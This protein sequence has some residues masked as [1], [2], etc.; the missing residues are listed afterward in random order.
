ML[1][2]HPARLAAVWCLLYC[3]CGAGDGD[4]GPQSGDTGTP[5]GALPDAPSGLR[6]FRGAIPPDYELVW[7]QPFGGDT[8]ETYVV[9]SSDA[10]FTDADPTLQL[11]EGLAEDRSAMI[12]LFTNSGEHHLRVAARDPQGNEGPLSEP[13]VVDTTLRLTFVANSNRDDTEELFVNIPGGDTPTV[14]SGA[15]VPFSIAGAAEWSPDGRRVAYVSD[16]EH[17]GTTELFLAAADG[18][19]EPERISG[20]TGVLASRVL[21]PEW[22]PTTADLIYASDR[23]VLGRFRTYLAPMNADDE[24]AQVGDT[25]AEEDQHVLALP[26]AWLRDGTRVVVSVFDSGLTAQLS[27][28]IVPID[29]GAAVE[30]ARR[31]SKGESFAFIPG[32]SPDERWVAFQSDRR[33]AG[34]AELFVAPADGSAAP[35]VISGAIPDGGNAEFGV[36]SPDSTLI[37]L[38][39]TNDEDESGE[40]YVVPPDGSGPRRLMSGTPPGR[41]GASNVQWSPDSRQIAFLSDKVVSTHRQAYVATVAVGGEPAKVG[42]D[43][44]SRGHRLL[45]WSPLGTQVAFLNEIDSMNIYPLHVAAPTDGSFSRAVSGDPETDGVDLGPIAW[46][47]SPDGAFLSFSGNA[48]AGPREQWIAL[49]NGSSPPARMSGVVPADR[50]VVAQSDRWSSL[51]GGR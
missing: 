47:W 31:E 24:P 34:K 7:D 8:P 1:V 18:V 5:R 15:I 4:E 50:A 46:Q 3:G 32:L 40:V 19:G 37:A 14:I 27:A 22:S 45:S 13:F 2:P 42:G 11:V 28:H 26:P 41:F 38:V 12:E 33:S 36:W 29:G 44:Q 49:A 9:Y 51:G 17:L 16:R 48:G 39:I 25:V 20:R 23:D 21:L 6:L 10:P 30:L 43:P 35:V